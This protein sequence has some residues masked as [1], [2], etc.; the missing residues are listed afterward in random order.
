MA[1]KENKVQSG[2]LIN[3]IKAKFEFKKVTIHP[4]K[5]EFYDDSCTV[6]NAED[7]SFEFNIK[8]DK[9]T[10]IAELGK[11]NDRV[12]IKNKDNGIIHIVAY[13]Y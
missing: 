3:Y 8:D 2:S 13:N 6:L 10:Y 1:K 7:N 9:R 12:L 5:T 4:N 11:N